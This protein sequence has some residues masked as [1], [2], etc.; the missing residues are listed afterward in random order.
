[1]LLLAFL[2]GCGRD[3]AGDRAAGGQTAPPVEAL[4][5][6]SGTLPLEEELSGIAR[7]R[8]QVAIRPEISAVVVEV[9]VRNG[10]RVSAG[11]PLVRLLDDT[12]REQLRQ[13]KASLEV[14]RAAA[15]EARA[16]VAEIEAQVVRARALREDGLVSALELETREAQLDAVRAQ[17]AQAQ[18][19]VAQAASTVQERRSALAKTVVRAPVSGRVGQRDVEVGMV[20]D[21]GTT[22]FLVGDFDDLIVEVPLT[23][24]MLAEISEGTPVEIAARGREGEPL[25]TEVSRISPFLE[26]SS[27]STT[28]EIDVDRPGHGLRP[29]MFVTV[30]VLYGETERATLVPVSAI[31]EEPRS[32]RAVVYVVEESSGLA[33]PDEPLSTIPDETRRVVRRPVSLLGNGRGMIGVTG[34]EPE[35]WVVTLGQQLLGE[36]L[37]ATE[38]DAVSAR[39][40]PTTWEHVLGLQELQRDDVLERFL[41][42]QQRVA[43]VLGAALPQSQDTVETALAGED[44]RAVGAE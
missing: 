26:Q 24:R 30:S 4:P 16:R 34:V 28:A 41:E 43:R 17:A 29:G 42:R 7:A 9:M 20:V 8:N 31:W 32:G 36:S 19:R 6:R 21:P 38:D 3:G 2:S 37:E 22:V 5:A 13:A 44:P 39:V 33:E 15:L 14:A 1:M 27:F 40:R 23:Q 10:D 35:E 25:R 11:Q 18:G 12:V